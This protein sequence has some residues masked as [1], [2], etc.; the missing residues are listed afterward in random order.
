ML[1]E[2]QGKEWVGGETVDKTLRIMAKKTWIEKRIAISHI[3][4]KRLIKNSQTFQ[5]E[6]KCLFLHQK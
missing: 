3:K 6:A 1:F 5:K 4:L 2:K